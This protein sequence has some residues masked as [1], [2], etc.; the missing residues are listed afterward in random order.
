MS[1]I[2]STAGR[3]KRISHGWD[4]CT[5]SKGR[6]NRCRSIAA[7]LILAMGLCVSLTVQAAIPASER[8]ALVDLYQSTNGDGWTD[9]SG[10]VG[11]VGTECS[12]YG[13]SCDSARAH[14]TRLSLTTNNLDGSLLGSLSDLSQLRMLDVSAN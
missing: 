3:T 2:F 14:V 5:R 8:Q 1:I 6:G 12:W 11:A 9:N 4:N 10:W 13:I 7:I